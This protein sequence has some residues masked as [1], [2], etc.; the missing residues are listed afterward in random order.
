MGRTRIEEDTMADVAELTARRRES[1]NGAGHYH[2]TDR[3]PFRV[4]A[5]AGG[6]ELASSDRVL[7]LKEVGASVYNPAFYFPP[8]DVDL[9]ALEREDGFTTQCPIKGTAS[10]WRLTGAAPVERIAWSYDTPL[11]YSQLIAGHLGFDQRY[12]TLEISPRS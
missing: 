9:S 1:P 3:Y 4:R 2:I 12:V 5:L 7:I 11:P 8:E 10:Y 6:R